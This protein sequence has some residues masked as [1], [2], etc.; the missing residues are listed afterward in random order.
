MVEGPPVVPGDFEVP[1][2]LFLVLGNHR[3]ALVRL[4]DEHNLIAVASN[5]TGSFRM[6]AVLKHIAKYYMGPPG[7]LHLH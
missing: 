7:K 5:H 3:L 2:E 1:L 6:V 4:L